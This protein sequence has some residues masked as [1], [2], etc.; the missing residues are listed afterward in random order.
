MQAMD[1]R[2]FDRLTQRVSNAGS[3][4]QALLAVLGAALVGAAT[5]EVAA[6]PKDNKVKPGKQC[7]PGAAPEAVPCDDR[8]N[9]PVPVGAEPEF[10]C[11]NG[12]C[13]CGGQCNCKNA[14]FVA[15]AP[16]INSPICC[17]GR[18]RK[19]CRSAETETCCGPGLG[20]ETCEDFHQSGIPGSYRRR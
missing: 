11:P 2:N 6:K 7:G 18:G 8:R 4:R 17:T 1:F 12:S 9:Y 16:S 19:I 13:S 3:R 14:C 15:E 20:C 10:C 5:G